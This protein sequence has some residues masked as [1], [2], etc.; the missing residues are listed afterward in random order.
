M[1]YNCLECQR[2][3]SL[4]EFDGT[5]YMDSYLHQDRPS[6]FTSPEIEPGPPSGVI[7]Y[8]HFFFPNILTL[9]MHVLE[10]VRSTFAPSRSVLYLSCNKRHT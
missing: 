2:S 9:D 4:A 7:Y 6:H 5:G 1:S 10:G 8:R 3:D